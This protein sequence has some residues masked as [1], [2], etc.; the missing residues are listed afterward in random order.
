MSGER[1]DVGSPSASGDSFR[2]NVNSRS[3]EPL[4]VTAELEDAPVVKDVP[5]PL[6]EPSARTSSSWAYQTVRTGAQGVWNTAY[7]MYRL[8]TFGK[9]P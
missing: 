2:S 8:T 6:M 3:G 4:G 9:T 5:G 1:R 7:S